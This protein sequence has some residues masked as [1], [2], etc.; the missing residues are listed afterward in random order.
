MTISSFV[1]GWSYWT[2]E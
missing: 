2:D 1:G